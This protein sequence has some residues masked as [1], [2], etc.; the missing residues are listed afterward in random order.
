MANINEK[1]LKYLEFVNRENNVRHHR[2]EEETRQ[3]S[4]LKAGDPRAIEEC[5]R[6]IDSPFVGHVSDDPLRNRKYLFVASVTLATR[7]AI[8]GGMDPEKAY[9]TSDLFIQEM[10]HCQST[11]AV[12]SLD[13]EM[14]TFFTTQLGKSKKE[15]VY[16]RPVVQCMDYI[17]YHLNETIS[18]QD[19]AKET[20]LHPGYL[21]SLF[22]REMGMTLT[23]YIRKQRVETAKNM[24]LYSEYSYAEIAA[25]LAFSSQSHFTRVFREETGYTPKA[26]Q[27]HF[28]RAG[29][30]QQH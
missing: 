8:E 13:L 26:Y 21:S 7:Y 17:Y 4:Y 14:M 19:L 10:D 1:R 5:K 6:M 11:E 22:H 24:L 20:G 2:Y 16:S 3:Y 15:T 28:F 27:T 23:E 25:I 18:L 29:I 9:N 30:G 12:K